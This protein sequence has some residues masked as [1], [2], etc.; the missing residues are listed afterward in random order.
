[1]LV[2][3]VVEVRG[4]RLRGVARNGVWSFSGVPY[5][6]STAGPRR[7]RPPVAPDPWV[8][9][10]ECDRFGPIA[11]QSPPLPGLSVAGEPDEHAEDCL[12]LNVWTPAI[13]GGHRPVMVWIHG[14]G[15][16]S[17]SGAGNLYRGGTLAREGNVVVVTINYRLGALGFLSHPVLAGDSGRGSG[18]WGIADQ[19]AALA[20][21]RDHIES[22]G[23]DP[24]NVTVFGESA[25]GMSVAALL[26]VPT[27]RGLFGRAIIESGPPY[28]HTAD[29]AATRAEELA[30]L[31]GVPLTREALQQTPAEELLRAT[32][33]LGRSLRIGDSLPLPFLPVV[34]GG[35]LERMP[36]DEIADGVASDI[37]LI[38]GTTRDEA[39]FFAV[40]SP[41]LRELDE[42]GLE[43][44]VR[45][46]TPSLEEAR[47]LI[48]AYRKER[49]ARGEA[50]T[51]RDLWVALATDTIFRLPS[52][53]LA[54]AHAAV[55]EQG[56]GTYV[57]LF[58][59]ETAAFGGALGSCHALEI[60]F[61]FGTVSNPSVQLFA[62]GGP[63]ALDLS[64]RMRQAWVSFAWSGAPSG[65]S[66]GSAGPVEWPLWD[67]ERRPTMVFGPWPGS[68]REGTRGSCRAVGR[69]RDDELT[70][71]AVAVPPRGAV[72]PR[73][74]AGR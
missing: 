13:D 54:D 39:A 31:L 14:G 57:Y 2:D 24:G 40:G 71:L 58:T 60:P 36:E 18:N 23:G 61:V 12:S 9:I 11:P 59:W 25:G 5:A 41:Q 7:W 74:A 50:V 68:D 65:W 63:E 15:F 19:V 10:K 73:S 32:D 16:T 55:A 56:V 21:V 52:L 45:T 1:M 44:W 26:A 20:W 6:G 70:A 62:G 8:G 42:P 27:A 66:D 35:L 72:P 51:T 33:E 64:A 49:S 34:D 48:G 47:A 38:I 46:V 30:R 28:T 3:G 29:Q 53:R 22:F 69:P 37:P 17:G 67:A 43:R 4:G